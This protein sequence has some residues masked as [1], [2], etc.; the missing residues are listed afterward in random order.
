MTQDKII[1]KFQN[2]EISKYLGGMLL[3]QAGA[4]QH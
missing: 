1:Q 4:F 2:I 3:A